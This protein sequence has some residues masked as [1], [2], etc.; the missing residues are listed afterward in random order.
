MP[1]RPHVRVV[2]R[3]LAAAV[4]VA[5]VV[6]CTAD[7]TGGAGTRAGSGAEPGP[8]AS[9]PVE[10]HGPGT[11]VQL[12]QWTWDAIGRECED[13]LGPA[14]YDFVLTSPPQ[15]HV[16]GE[17]WWTAYQPVS[18]LLE[19][20]LGTR[21]ELAAMVRRCDAAGVAVLTDAVINHMTGKDEP[22]TGWAGSPYEHY[23]YPGL[24]SDAEGDFHHCDLTPEDDIQ[25]YQVAA[26]VQ[27]CELVNL[28]DLATE[29]PRVRERIVAYLEDLLGLGVAGFR[30]D[31]A[32]HMPAEDVGAVVGAL[33][34]GTLV[35]QEVIGARGEPIRPEDYLSNGHVF[36]F[37]HGQELAAVVGGGS[38]HRALELGDLDTALPSDRSVVFVENHDTER[39]G[40]TLSYKD[41]ATYVQSLVLL[42]ALDHGTPVVHSGYAFVDRD[43]GPPQTPG[44]EVV[45]ATC[46]DDV[47]PDARPAVG[48]FVCQH[49]WAPVAGMV[50]WRDAVAGGA[51][52]DV[53]VGRRAVAFGR[54]GAGFVVVNGNAAPLEETFATRLPAGTYC[55]VVTG[56][57]VDGRCTGRTVD[58]DGDGRLTAELAGDTALAVHVGAR[59]GDG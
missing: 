1:R 41:G 51:V 28:A 13:V 34:E 32:K 16:L 53:W 47:G 44:G 29:E 12:F 3:A 55:D 6:G 21:E 5:L 7:P 50:G 52:E 23:E 25:S 31:A 59:E 43:A 27:R 33:P 57:L 8:T 56:A 2:V 9:A 19:S 18:Y 37:F 49:R 11:G 45:D 58:V 26:Q 54:G 22:G 17:E 10:P 40:S 14:G 15:E 35:L 42:L 36:D 46:A 38:V 48:T 39:N 4:A 24:Y 20:R 30:I